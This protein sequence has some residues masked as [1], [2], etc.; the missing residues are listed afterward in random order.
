M[1]G[2]DMVNPPLFSDPGISQALNLLAN[3]LNRNLFFQKNLI[4]IPPLFVTLNREGKNHFTET[5]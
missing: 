3:T 4:P 5:A 1:H 2:G